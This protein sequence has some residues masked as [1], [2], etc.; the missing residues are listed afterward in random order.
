M[1]TEA[2]PQAQPEQKLRLHE[3]T[4]LALD[5]ERRI[6]A[7]TDAAPDS[8]ALDFA[9]KE[10]MESIEGNIKET[11]TAL[12][13]LVLNREA[14]AEALSAQAD[15]LNERARA[16]NLRA[17]A[18]HHGAERLRDYIAGSLAALGTGTQKVN[19]NGLVAVTLSK[20]S[21]DKLAVVDAAELPD[22]FRLN[23]MEVPTAKVPH[24]LVAYTTGYKANKDALA[25]DGVDEAPPTGTEMRTPKRRL[26]VR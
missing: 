5:V 18:I 20:Q 10:A 4:D 14:D 7:I 11:A 15:I 21:A 13:A 25:K 9:L 26:L 17:D 2:P 24:T 6:D 12:A 23:V 3:L 22:A 8:D 16:I 1:T 19:T